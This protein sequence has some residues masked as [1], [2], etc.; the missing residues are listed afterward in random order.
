VE[1]RPIW[2][3]FGY[4]AVAIALVIGGVY[5]LKTYQPKEVSKFEL[6]D[7]TSQKYKES[8][9]QEGQS[10]KA[11]LTGSKVRPPTDFKKRDPLAS[12][13]PLS[14]KAK[15]SPISEGLQKGHLGG[16][17][18]L[19]MTPGEKMAVSAPSKAIPK[20]ERTP[21]NME[22]PP[23]EVPVKGADFSDLKQLLAT[24]GNRI[25]IPFGRDSNDIP[26]SAFSTLDQVAAF[27]VRHPGIRLRI[28]GYTDARG[29]VSYNKRVSEFRATTIKSYLVGKGGNPAVIETYGLGPENPI[30]SNE[31]PEGRQANRRVELEFAKEDLER[32]NVF[33]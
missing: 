22:A 19:M 8:L 30:G 32:L 12:S 29:A 31:T 20:P 13:K 15:K 4:A 7:L 9:Q 26:D 16:V 21:V 1:K 23:S 3:R 6:Q 18:E 17:K 5:F 10:L 2:I 14:D 33:Q 25:I 11:E 28:K 27:V 24:S